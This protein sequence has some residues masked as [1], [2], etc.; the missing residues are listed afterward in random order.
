MNSSPFRFALW[1]SPLAAFSLLAAS[2]ASLTSDWPQWLGPD[3]TGVVP[4]GVPVPASLPK[5]MKSTWRI[6]V[7]GGFSSPVVVGGKLVYADENG[8]NE[9]CHLLDAK[10]G[11]EL[12]KTPYAPAK[13]DNFGNG[14]RATPLVDGE[15]IYVQSVNGEFACLALADGKKLWSTSFEKD[16]GVAFLGGNSDS[17]TSRRRGNN[18]SP[19]VD[20][21]HIIVPVGSTE[22]GTLVCFDK[23]TGKQIWAG[24]NDETAYSAVQVATLAG[25][26]QALV[27][28]A[29]ALLSLDRAT[30][31]LL[32]RVPLKTGAKRHVATPVILGDRVLVNSHTF[33]TIAFKVV[34]QGAEVKAFEDWKNPALKINL[35]TPVLVNGHLFS[36]GPAKNFVCFDPATG[37]QKWVAP[38]FGKENSSVLGLGKN[39]LVLTDEGQ[40]VLIAGEADAYR[41]IS[42]VQACGK[43]WNFPA[44]A[45]G[46]LYVRDARELA[47]YPLL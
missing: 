2:A 11:K 30:G 6:N 26:R 22:K 8:E 15:R 12:W 43:N 5:D 24:G 18:G 13:G 28:D 46:H 33:G 44:Y 35:A 20:G 1:L 3:R 29:E 37:A 16:F 42:R 4:A 47:C 17:G 21:P 31:R 38:G 40:L 7:G 27:L 41:E 34:K 19:V 14:P 9:F 23:L 10:T 45:G 36:H 39:L 32:W 25:V